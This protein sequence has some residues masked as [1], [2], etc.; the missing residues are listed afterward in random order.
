M[1]VL[2]F[3]KQHWFKF[4]VIG[5]LVVIFFKKEVSL[6]I[7]LNTPK[8][9]S[10]E[11][12]QVAPQQV[13]ESPTTENTD[14]SSEVEQMS[15]QDQIASLPFW[16]LGRTDVPDV[17][18]EVEIEVLDNYINRFARLAR[19]EK[20]QHGIPAAI[21]LANALLLSQVGQSELANSA[22]NHFQ[23]RC[24]EDWKGELQWNK[25][26][27]Y[28][29]YDRAWT[30][31]RDFSLFLTTGKNE[32]LLQL[33]KDDYTAWANAIEATDFFEQPQLAKKLLSIIEKYNLKH[34]DA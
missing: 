6:G 22:R 33:P 32:Q 17:L 1:S 27:C 26:E 16:R 34:L 8:K 15:I 14:V 29:V 20:E 23:L 25:G 18:P 7:D 28:R 11:E 31:F 10:A 9:A 2:N 12:A 5:I 3:I 30:S 13:P 24:T 19:G 21:I 4:V